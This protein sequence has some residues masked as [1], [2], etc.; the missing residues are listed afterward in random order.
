MRQRRPPHHYWVKRLRAG[1]SGGRVVRN[2]RIGRVKSG[3][4]GRIRRTRGMGRI[5]GGRSVE[6]ICQVG[7]GR[8]RDCTGRRRGRSTSSVKRGCGSNRSNT[9]NRRTTVEWKK[10]N[11]TLLLITQT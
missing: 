11:T 1:R 4:R 9:R 8:V 6:G 2:E 3:G 5:G 7:R 10:K